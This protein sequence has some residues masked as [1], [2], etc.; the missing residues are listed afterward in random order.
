MMPLTK[1]TPKA[2]VKLNGEPLLEWTLER[3]AKAGIEEIIIVTGYLEEK[4]R[5]YFGSNYMGVPL[6]YVRQ[7]KQLG[8]AHAISMAKGFLKGK[9]IA[10]NAD[11]VAEEKL[12]KRLV[13]MEKSDADIVIVGREVKEPWR[14]GVIKEENGKIIDLVEKPMR[15]N[16]PSKIVNAGIYLFNEKIFTAIMKTPLSERGEY[17]ITDSIKIL[18]KSDGKAVLEHC[19]GKI[20]DIGSIDDLKKA[21][22]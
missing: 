2:M 19:R 20:I 12:Y 11:V 3:L 22:G 10:V 1:D 5:N 15:G 13:G 21:E 14:Y 4:I 6:R 8:T 17:E 18:I 16:E 9:F 7:E